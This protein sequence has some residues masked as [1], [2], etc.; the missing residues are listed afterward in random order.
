MTEFLSGQALSGYL[1][2]NV[3]IHPY[4]IYQLRSLFHLL[5]NAAIQVSQDFVTA[6]PCLTVPNKKTFCWQNAP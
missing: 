2:K 5:P 6:H 1:D 3:M 4:M